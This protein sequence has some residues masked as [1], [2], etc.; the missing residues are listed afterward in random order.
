MGCDTAWHNRTNYRL[1][2]AWLASWIRANCQPRL[3]QLNQSTF[4]R[5][6]NE[7]DGGCCWLEIFSGAT[8][9]CSW[10]VSSDNKRVALLA[11]NWQKRFP[12]PLSPHWGCFGLE[13][14]VTESEMIGMY[15]LHTKNGWFD[16]QWQERGASEWLHQ[17]KK[18]MSA[19]RDFSN[20][21]F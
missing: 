9:S 11:L 12:Y 6:L 3:A 15:H 10:M 8:A 18:E 5:S 7:I 17:F 16:K 21:T 2:R 14:K 20:V 13:M 1:S 19:H 4:R